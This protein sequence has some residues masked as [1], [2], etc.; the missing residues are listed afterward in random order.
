MRSLVF[1]VVIALCQQVLFAQETAV[2]NRLSSLDRAIVFAVQHEVQVNKLESKL[3]TCIGFGHGLVV[4]EKG[5]IA[6][7]SRRGVKVRSDEWCSR[8]KRGSKIDIIAPTSET[9][10]GTYE[11]TIER[12]T[13][14]RKEDLGTL[15]GRAIYTVKCKDG[16]EPELLAYRKTCCPE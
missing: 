13:L 11:F 8:G 1:A 2:A 4:D 14:D 15:L 9:V 5:I 12:G 7:L 6:E 3:E 10:S 16:S